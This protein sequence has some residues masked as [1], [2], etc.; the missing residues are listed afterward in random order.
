MSKDTQD[1][2]QE[3]LNEYI[4]EMFRLL[5]LMISGFKEVNRKNFTFYHFMMDLLD[6]YC[7][8]NLYP[9]LLKTQE[10]QIFF[11]KRVLQK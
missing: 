8:L 1:K 6:T 2:R 9:S 3:Q 7:L 11:C 10:M 5:D 4:L